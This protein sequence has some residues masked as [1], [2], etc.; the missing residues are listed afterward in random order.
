VGAS[1]S[2]TAS[3]HQLC[4]RPLM[5]LAYRRF[6]ACGEGGCHPRIASRL[7]PTKSGS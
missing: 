5:A 4:P 3:V 1:R 6:F 2:T 7:A